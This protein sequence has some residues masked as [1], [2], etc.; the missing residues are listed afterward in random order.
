MKGQSEAEVLHSL[1]VALMSKGYGQILRHI[2]LTEVRVVIMAVKK[3]DI[4]ARAALAPK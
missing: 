2:L 3:A 1:R 4:D